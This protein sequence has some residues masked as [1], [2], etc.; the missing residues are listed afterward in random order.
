MQ[1]T[2]DN[3]QHE[4]RRQQQLRSTHSIRNNTCRARTFEFLKTFEAFLSFYQVSGG[5]LGSRRDQGETE[6]VQGGLGRSGVA[7]EVL[8]E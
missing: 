4:N 1:K 8:M 7:P 2:N 3:N 5:F 6:K